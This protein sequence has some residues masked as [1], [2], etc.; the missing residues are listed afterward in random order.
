MLM[1]AVAAPPER[2]QKEKK[3]PVLKPPPALSDR[4]RPV[5]AETLGTFALTLV[6][7][8]G[9][10]IGALSH[11]EVGH[12]ARAVAPGMLV[13]ALIY[14]LG[15]ASGA[16]FNPAVT[17]A[18][19]ARRDFPWSRVPGY[20]A[21]QMAGA[22]LAAALLRSLFGPVAHLGATLPRFGEWPAFVME[23]A[24][25]TLLL[26]VILGTATRY[27]LVGPNAAIAVG[28]T[29]ALCGLFAGPV[30]GASMN[31][32]RSLGPAIVSGDVGHV[33]IY[34]LAPLLGSA[35]ATVLVCILHGPHDPKEG[36]AAQGD[37]EHKEGGNKT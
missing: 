30:S 13:M 7:A 20:W 3:P 26:L 1:L 8:G 34:V 28:A 24:L 21:A 33:W 16:H 32:A 35:L 10:V 9:E 17:F 4:L 22:T 6:A 37:G 15:D 29:I 31:P 25:S 11:D 27:S 19:A 36:E 14:A 12:A 2:R 5:L 18:F 23:V